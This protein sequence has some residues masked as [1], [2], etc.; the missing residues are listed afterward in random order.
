MKSYITKNGE[1]H[2]YD[3]KAQMK[4]S[5]EKH[6][7]KYNEPIYCETCKKS[8][9]KSNAFHHNNTKIHKAIISAYSEKLEQS[10]ESKLL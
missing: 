8:Y 10:K 3:Y 2:F 1:E 7:E 4:K 9:G 6:K 5:Y